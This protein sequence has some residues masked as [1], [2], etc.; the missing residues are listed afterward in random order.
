MHRGA[1]VTRTSLSIQNGSAGATVLAETFSATHPYSL[2]RGRNHAYWKASQLA[3]RLLK[4]LHH[5]GPRALAG[6][7]SCGNQPAYPS[8]QARLRALPFALGCFRRYLAHVVRRHAMDEHWEIGVRRAISE[9]L[10]TSAGGPRFQFIELAGR[11]SCADPFPIVVDNVVHLFCEDAPLRAGRGTIAHA[12]IGADGTAGPVQTVLDEPFHLSY[13]FV[14]E[15]NGAMYMLPETRQARRVALYRAERFPDRWVRDRTL[16]EDVEASDPTLLEYEGRLWLF[17]CI[18]AS[19]ESPTDEL[20]AFHADGLDGVWQPHPGN[21]IV[22]D[23]RRAR[24]A[25]RFFVADNMLIRPS[26]DC[27]KRYGYGVGFNRVV[28]LTPTTYVERPI[29]RLD[30]AALGDRLACHTYNRCAGYEWIDAMR[31]VPRW[32]ALFRRHPA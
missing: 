32:P 12:V 28:E 29:E 23:V 7:E 15:H 31:R 21:P 11:S 2:F 3:P 22:S 17:L 26:Q 8:S 9:H 5:G 6:T 14:F 18:S 25:G 1:E 13:P 20:F 4:R 27:A 10:P 19:A 24:P 16:I 30:A